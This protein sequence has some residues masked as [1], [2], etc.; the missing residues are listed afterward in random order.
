VSPQYRL[1]RCDLHRQS[2]H[3]LWY[4][5]LHVSWQWHSVNLCQ[6]LLLLS[7][8]VSSLVVRETFQHNWRMLTRCQCVHW[9]FQHRCIPGR[10]DDVP[11]TCN[12]VRLLYSSQVHIL[13]WTELSQVAHCRVE[14]TDPT[15]LHH[16][17]GGSQQNMWGTHTFNYNTTMV[18]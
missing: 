14:L 4:R 17:F 10:H 12:H 6:P 15:S 18:V 13:W 8:E 7:L 3:G 16:F 5:Q 11:Q 9:Q 1:W 2:L